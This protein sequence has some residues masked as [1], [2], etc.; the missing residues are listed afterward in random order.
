[1]PFDGTANVTVPVSD[2]NAVASC[3][4]IFTTNTATPTLTAGYN[5]SSVTYA[6]PGA[7]DVSF[8]TPLR[9]KNYIINGTCEYSSGGMRTV[10]SGESQTTKTT[11]KFRIVV[12]N[13]N[14]GP[15][16]SPNASVVTFGGL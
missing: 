13:A 5:V 6:G 11:A 2:S 4:A 16:S 10:T 12:V 1:M 3:W 15:D 7:Y 14:N 9:N 8:I